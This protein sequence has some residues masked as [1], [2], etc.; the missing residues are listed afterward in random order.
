MN[1]TA[2]AKIILATGAGS[3]GAAV[4]RRIVPL[5]GFHGPSGGRPG[6]LVREDQRGIS[7]RR[8]GTERA[9][10]NKGK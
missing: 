6:R 9:L 5:G 3:R 2:A 10:V 4:C 7:N 8:W 1:E